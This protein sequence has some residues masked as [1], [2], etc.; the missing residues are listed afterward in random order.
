MAEDIDI[1]SCCPICKKPITCTIDKITILTASKLPVPFKIEHCGTTFIILIDANFNCIETR[2]LFNHKK[3]DG[4]RSHLIDSEFLSKLTPDDLVVFEYNS[5]EGFIL[6]RIPDLAEK[7]LIRVISKSQEVSLSK[8]IRECAIL[9][10]ALNRNIN[11]EDLLNI[12]DKYVEKEIIIQQ[13]IKIEEEE[14]TSQFKTNILQG[15]NI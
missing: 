1:T 8:L 11:R 6:D 14:S 7:H 4:I 9:G 5:K 13:E 15:G 3:E 12:L 10:K 2:M